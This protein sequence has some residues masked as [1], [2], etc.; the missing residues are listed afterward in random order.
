MR[1]TMHFIS[2]G[3]IL[4]VTSALSAT[5][6]NFVHAQSGGAAFGAPKVTAYCS[7]RGSLNQGALDES[8]FRNA[9]A[10]MAGKTGAQLV[11]PAGTYRLGSLAIA[12]SN[13]TLDCEPGAILQPTER[14]NGI[15][16]TGDNVVF[17]GCT[18]DLDNIKSGP[19]MMV[20]KASGFALQ[21]GALIHIGQQPGLQL[22]QTSNVVIDKNR[23]VTDGTGDAVFAYGPTANIRITNNHGVG[24]IDVDSGRNA[25]GA[26]HGV[27]FTGNVLQPVT[28]KTILTTGDFSDGYG[29][30]SPI[31]QIVILGNTCNIKAASAAVAPFGCYSLVGGDG[32]TFTNNTMNAVGQYVGD[33]LVEMGTADATISNN[34]FR[35]GND[36]GAQTYNDM[37]IYCASVRLSNNT[38]NGT[39]ARGDAIRIYPQSNADDISISEGSITA[40]NS[41]GARAQN[42]AITIACNENRIPLRVTGVAGGGAKGPVT[43][44]AIG[45][46]PGKNAPVGGG[47]SRTTG[48]AVTGASGT[49]LKLDILSVDARGGIMSLGVS[50]GYAGNNYAMG[51]VVYLPV[52]G[53]E[54]AAEARGVEIDG[55]TISGAF[56]HAVDIQSFQ[57]ASCPVSAELQNLTISGGSDATPI[58]VGVYER[59]ATVKSGAIRFAHVAKA[60]DADR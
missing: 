28:G 12:T 46:Y 47:F 38:F 9:F 8:C 30:A 56:L 44:V 35:A 32:L 3:T 60:T 23:F 43:S 52:S 26:S 25:R 31:T 6:A 27:V 59:G 33:S 13:V 39:S 20:T 57:E 51:E 37:I 58:E 41:R 11:V 49:G 54:T 14:S 22:N 18:F 53:S 21:N 7:N 19:G 5:Q 4:V 15:R 10:A 16:V 42:N 48:V 2:R 29:P 24:S 55:L 34:T 17:D 45:Q 50:P 1:V 40:D 36:P